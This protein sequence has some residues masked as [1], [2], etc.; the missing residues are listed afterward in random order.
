MYPE[1]SRACE[2]CQIELLLTR[3]NVDTANPNKNPRFVEILA[4]LSN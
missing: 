2:L 4:S 3:F 1:I